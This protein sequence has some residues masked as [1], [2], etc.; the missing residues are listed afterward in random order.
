MP[1]RRFALERGGPRRLR[2]QWGREGLKVFLDELEVPPA[3]PHPNDYRLPDGSWVHV[4]VDPRFSTVDVLRDG[5]F[6]PGTRFDP[7]HQLAVAYGILFAL[8]ALHAVLIVVPL[9]RVMP[10]ALGRSLGPFCVALAAL[11][12]LL[13]WGVL[14]R[15]KAA[16]IGGITLFVAEGVVF[17][18]VALA[19]PARRLVIYAL[20]AVGA[21]LLQGL[22]ALRVL[23]LSEKSPAEP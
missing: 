19:F 4:D 22:D 15:S 11:Y 7:F 10:A 13:G 1:Q 3:G 17:G 21:G 23:A 8:A 20:L 18:T 2:V 6:L 9:E 16:L 14:L 5:D 12:A